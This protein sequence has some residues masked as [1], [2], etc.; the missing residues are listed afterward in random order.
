MPVI[1]DTLR[2]IDDTAGVVHIE[3]L[4]N[5]AILSLS[6]KIS[7]MPGEREYTIPGTDT[8][9]I[10][11]KGELMLVPDIESGRQIGEVKEVK[12]Y[13]TFNNIIVINGTI[14]FEANL[15]IEVS[16]SDTGCGF[17]INRYKIPFEDRIETGVK[18][19]RKINIR[20]DKVENRLSL[21]E[22]CEDCRL[23]SISGPVIAQCVFRVNV[24]A[25]IQ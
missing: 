25:E 21:N 7:I 11:N 4:M 16:F 20:G 8:K 18:D 14:N 10:L 23:K 3:I 5:E 9:V 12:S 19:I 17:D 15:I 6:K 24:T 22:C 13:V 2:P 1:L